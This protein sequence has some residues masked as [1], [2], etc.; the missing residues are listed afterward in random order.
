M[1]SLKEACKKHGLNDKGNLRTL[2]KRVR[3][4]T[5]EKND[6]QMAFMM[7][8]E[9]NVTIPLPEVGKCAPEKVFEI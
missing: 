4:N 5:Q 6:K 3:L 1:A 2:R 9:S 7:M 8:A